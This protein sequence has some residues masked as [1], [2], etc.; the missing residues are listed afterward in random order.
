MSDLAP[1]PQSRLV[2]WLQA[3]VIATVM[4]AITIGGS[5]LTITTKVVNWIDTQET[6]VSANHT[7]TIRNAADIADHQ[8]AIVSLDLRINQLSAR[9]TDLHSQ[10]DAADAAMRARL[11]VID[12]LTKFAADRAMQPNL[13]APYQG[14]RR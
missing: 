11:D 7:D 4:L 8:R 9:V 13:P 2:T 1:H 6:Q 3:N 5:G 14:S 12:A 10:S